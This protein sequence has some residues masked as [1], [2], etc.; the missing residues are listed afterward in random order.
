MFKHNLDLFLKQNNLKI[1]N[2][3][4]DS[5]LN[6]YLTQSSVGTRVILKTHSSKDVKSRIENELD[7]Y[8]KID[9]PKYNINTPKLLS[10]T[11][12]DGTIFLILEYIEGENYQT[13]IDNK[14]LTHEDIKKL[15][16]FT[17]NI[18]NIDYIPTMLSI[19]KK[20]QTIDQI[21]NKFYKYAK[22]WKEQIDVKL[23]ELNFKR[24]S[25]F[26]Y[27][28]YE[29]SL[30]FKIET[31]GYGGRHGSSKMIE[32]IDKVG[33]LYV[34]DWEMATTHYIKYYELSGL[35]GFIIARLNM[36]DFAKN[37]INYRRELEHDKNHFDKYFKFVLAERLLGD[38]WDLFYVKNFTKE[39]L[40]EKLN[41]VKNSWDELT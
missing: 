2:Q 25:E 7:T 18:E 12:I 33:T 19:E 26:I 36:L 8:L 24:Y 16:E 32:F 1:Q 6:T 13:K 30:E 9:F 31:V 11:E 37:L 3:F 5:H 17:F 15:A 35:V 20:N 23:E 4:N 38:I 21:D 41:F 27:K 14:N 28:L 34:I 29:T 40:E 22:N 10:H 39:I